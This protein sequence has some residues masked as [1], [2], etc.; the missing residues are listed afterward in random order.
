MRFTGKDDGFALATVMG[1]VALITA[2]ALAG[3]F[4][5]EQT[6]NESTRVSNE[7][8]AYQA[9]ASALE[10]ELSIFD[11]QGFLAGLPS[12]SGY[13]YGQPEAINGRDKFVLS[14]KSV[15]PDEYEMQSTGVAENTSETVA[16]RFQAIN[17]WDMNISGDEQMGA[18][19]G[20]NGN[21]TI[22]GK[23][24]CSGDF[25]WTG[26]AGIEGGPVFVTNGKFIKQ[27]LGC[28]VGTAAEPV[29]GY[30]DQEPQVT[31]GDT[32]WNVETRGSAPK[33]NIPWPTAADMANWER[34]AR[35]YALRNR[36]DP[37]MPTHV[38]AAADAYTVLERDSVIGP[39]IFGKPG[40]I[41]RRPDGSIDESA[42]GDV[43]AVARSANGN[44]MT[45]HINGVVYVKGT[46]TVSRDIKYYSGRGVIVTTNG[47][48][49]DG[50]LVPVRY[51]NT[52][53]SPPN[54]EPYTTADGK[55]E[56]L[57]VITAQDA[58]CFVSTGNVDVTGGD[59]VAG[60]FFLSGK[61]METR[62]AGK[63]RGSIIA[64]SIDW[65]LPNGWMV[66][67]PGLASNLPPEMPP[68]N[69][70]NAAG[71]WRRF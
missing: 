70:I 63:F 19:A 58:L 59:W 47:V 14:V 10:R 4:L 26:S 36:P 44:G 67:Q 48:V 20:F 43:I 2:V 24:F 60:A 21:G 41:A 22:I 16:V 32:G 61:F 11:A 38:N 18:G 52:P 7:N 9:A 68:L 1:A 42:S 40:G 51:D 28:Y 8:R 3:F 49:I 56:R 65:A 13:V 17:L 37:M 45:L 39:T 46:L 71:D 54:C 66:T 69:N 55:S 5:A 34:A 31:A 35:N 57:P 23:V 62:T 33:L 53:Y 29:Y 50:R 25:E 12:K 6:L 15:G 27:S 64:Q 30:F